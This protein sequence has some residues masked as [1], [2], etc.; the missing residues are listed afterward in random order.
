M[1]YLHII[2]E[3]SYSRLW[4]GKNEIKKNKILKKLFIQK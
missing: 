4:G 1:L 3:H 2:R